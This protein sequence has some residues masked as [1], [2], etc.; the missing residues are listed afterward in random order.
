MRSLGRLF[1]VCGLAGGLCKGAAADECSVRVLN[2]GR[3]MADTVGVTVQDGA[4]E[5]GRQI[6]Y[7]AQPD[8]SVSKQ[9]QHL[10]VSRSDGTVLGWLVGKEKKIVYTP[11]RVVGRMVD[12][13]WMDRPDSYAIL[14]DDDPAYAPGVAPAAVFR[15]TKPSDFARGEGW[16]FKAPLRHVLYLKGAKPFQEG[17]RYRI[18]FA[19]GALPEQSF[20]CDSA[21][22]RSEAVHV[23]HLGFRPDDPA[24]VAFLSCWLGSGG[25]VAY[26]DG[27]TFRIVEDR[28]STRLNS[29]H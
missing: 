20:V 16:P 21:G 9:E 14:S 12:T 17:K 3:V 2:V 22:L 8:D 1:V 23:S 19:N 5:Y 7:E 10:I 29:S 24:K 26:P 11:D 15:K 6:P 18:R 4:L 25:A 13:K 28:K 27:L